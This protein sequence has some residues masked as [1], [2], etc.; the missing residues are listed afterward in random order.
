M[1]SASFPESEGR[2]ADHKPNRRALKALMTGSVARRNLSPPWE[3]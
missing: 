1:S 3:K 2:R